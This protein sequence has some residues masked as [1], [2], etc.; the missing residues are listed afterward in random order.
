MLRFIFWA[1]L[2]TV[3]VLPVPFGG[4]YPW[5]YTLLAVVVAG[6][7]GLW[8]AATVLGRAA[9]PVPPRKVWLPFALYFGVI[10]WMFVQTATWTPAAWH[11]PVWADAAR[12]LGRPLAGRISVDPVAA[13]AVAMRLLSYA[14]IFWLALQYG[15]SERD[16]R[17]V[18]YAVAVAGAMYAVYGLAVEFTGSETI[19][20]FEKERYGESLTSTFRYKNSY[21]TFAGLTL[22][23]TLAVF[24]E[25]V[26]REN[27]AALGPRER[28]RTV[29]SLAFGRASYI[30]LGFILILSALLLSDSRGGFLA[31]LVAVG[32]FTG[33]IAFLSGRRFYYRWRILGMLAA[34]GTLFVAIS[35]GNVLDRLARTSE[36]DV[37]VAIYETT[38]SAIGDRPLLGW[39]AGTF[40]GVFAQYQPGGFTTRPRRAHNEYLDTALELG[41]PA[42]AA[43]AIS[44]GAIGLMC[45]H[46]TR[47]RRRNGFYPA[48]GLAAV[49][50]VGVHA[51]S[52][53][54][55]QD[56]GVPALFALLLGVGCAQSWNTNGCGKEHAARQ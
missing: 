23:A 8:T 37:R 54:S 4:I 46:G 1:L 49:V 52:D 31:T 50:L 30:L 45:A 11:A 14:A 16:A 25:T 2:V 41:I 19:L 10:A 28:L 7:T 21:A 29:L 5:S 13:N 55:L 6:L 36:T 9:P 43:L 17:R 47:R 3:L 42:A 12:V 53:F 15:R 18:L 22:I 39:G 24:V 35:G 32:V 38:L 56:P 51:A 40:E 48:A 26:S 33:A 27:F 34:V 20:W 44:I